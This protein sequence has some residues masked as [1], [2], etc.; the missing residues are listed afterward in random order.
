LQSLSSPKI[1]KNK[2][3]TGSTRQAKLSKTTC[4]QSKATLLINDPN[5]VGL[6]T[7]KTIRDQ[8]VCREYD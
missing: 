7:V 5:Y 3:W 4:I 6:P 1:K 2:L 8:T